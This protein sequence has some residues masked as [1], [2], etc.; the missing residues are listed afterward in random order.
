M[1]PLLRAACGRLVGVDLSA[2][3]CGK[4]VERGC[5]DLVEVGEL[6]QWLQRQVE[7]RKEDGQGAGHHNQQQQEQQQK[8]QQEHQQAEGRGTQRQERQGGG[9][10]TRSETPTSSV[11]GALFDLLVA[12]DVLVYIGR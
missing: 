7:V 1:G 12:A 11:R 9:S 8:Q 4:A 3:M 2:G 10:A 6:V 5:Y